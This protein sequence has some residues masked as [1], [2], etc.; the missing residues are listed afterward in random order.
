MVVSNEETDNADHVPFYRREYNQIVSQITYERENPQ[1][2]LKAVW[3][4]KSYRKRFLILLWFF[5][6]Q[7]LTAVIPLQN[8][9]V[10]LYKTLGIGTK[11]S[12]VL[13]GVLNFVEM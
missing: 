1:L 8:Y 5:L 3:S 6:G 2:G 12:L 11:M 9:Q 10:I 13:V 4:N 7:Q